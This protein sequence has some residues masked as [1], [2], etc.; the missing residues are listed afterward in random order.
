MPLE[1]QLRPMANLASLAHRIRRNSLSV[2]EKNF[3]DCGHLLR[4]ILLLTSTALCFSYILFLYDV[5][6]VYVGP[7]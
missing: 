1:T 7:N 6:V 2:N 4:I 3:G 5:S